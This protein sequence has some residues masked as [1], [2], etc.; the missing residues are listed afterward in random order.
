MEQLI[1]HFR[2]LGFSKIEAECIIVL[3]ENG[4]S[5]GYEI[6]KK[7]GA[8]RSNVYAALQR[9]YEN[10][11]VTKVVG[12]STT[13]IVQDIQSIIKQI[14]EEQKK[15]LLYIERNMPKP[16]NETPDFFSLEGDSQLI[17][18]FR[19]EMDKAQEIVLDL[20]Q[21]EVELFRED[22]LVAESKRKHVVLFCV[23]E[24]DIPLKHVFLH[25]REEEWALRN[26]RK[27]SGIFDRKLV[28]LGT[29]GDH[30]RTKAVVSEHPS[31]V[32]LLMNHAFHDLVLHEIRRDLGVELENRYGRN[33]INVYRTYFDHT[34]ENE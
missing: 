15:S 30:I 34:S 1:Q 10:R 31:M 17:A 21:E 8:S 3:T 26:G 12:E 18:R 14:E 32:A 7:I 27:L 28:I 11:F 20:W 6:A 33:F 29:R 13:Y 24:T 25:G 9:L 5:N 19:K 4:P 16:R 22:L 23:G 2:N